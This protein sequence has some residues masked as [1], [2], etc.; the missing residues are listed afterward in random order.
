MGKAYATAGS[1]IEI[2]GVSEVYSTSGHFDLLVK[3]HISDELDTGLF[4][5]NHIQTV[6]GVQD[7]LTIITFNAFAT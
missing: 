7:T 3:C 4:V 2:D 6:D 1:I 5:T